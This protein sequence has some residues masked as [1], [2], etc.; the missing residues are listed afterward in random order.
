MA[1][2]KDKAV[3]AAGPLG[4]APSKVK[5]RNPA[6]GSVIEVD[7]SGDGRD[8]SPEAIAEELKQRGLVA[9]EEVEVVNPVTGSKAMVTVERDGTH[10]AKLVMALADKGKT[11]DQ[12][13]HV[14][15]MYLFERGKENASFL[16]DLFRY[17][18]AHTKE[19]RAF[20]SQM[21]FDFENFVSLFCAHLDASARD[22]AEELGMEFD[23]FKK[24]ASDYASWLKDNRDKGFKDFIVACSVSLSGGAAERAIL[25]MAIR[26]VS[27]ADRL[28]D[29]VKRVA[30]ARERE[31]GKGIYI[32]RD[33]R[34]YAV[35]D[36]SIDLHEIIEAD[37]KRLSDLAR[38]DRL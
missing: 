32:D 29:Y 24:V 17:K 15:G 11:R 3:A 28:R 4:G 37:K 13:D 38:E 9:V 18:G 5:A 30:D 22:A 14:L 33:G 31:K 20:K 25:K 27:E 36:D 12:K 34:P 10:E 7:L 6:D 2:S 19:T 21:R 26:N 35:T 16:M 1:N 23:A 8:Y